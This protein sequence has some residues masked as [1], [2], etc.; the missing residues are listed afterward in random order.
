ME[1]M[2]LKARG[3]TASFS[4]NIMDMITVIIKVD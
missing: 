3:F 2:Q 4:S 1:S